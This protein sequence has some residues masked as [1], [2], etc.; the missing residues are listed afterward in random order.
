MHVLTRLH[1]PSLLPCSRGAHGACIGAEASALVDEDGIKGYFAAMLLTGSL[2]V[3]AKNL[4]ASLGVGALNAVS[5]V[6]IFG[7][8]IVVSTAVVIAAI[9]KL[10]QERGGILCQLPTS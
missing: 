2:A 4:S 7:A 10:Q 9:C 1:S 8:A 6:L 5:I 3:A